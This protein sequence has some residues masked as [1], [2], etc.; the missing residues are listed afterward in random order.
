[1]TVKEY[2]LSRVNSGKMPAKLWMCF[3]DAFGALWSEL[4]QMHVT[5]HLERKYSRFLVTRRKRI[6]TIAWLEDTIQPTSK[7][8]S[9]RMNAFEWPGIW[10]GC[11]MG[12]HKLFNVHVP[13]RIRWEFVIENECKGRER[14]LTESKGTEYGFWVKRMRKDYQIN[15]SPFVSSEWCIRHN[16]TPFEQLCSNFLVNVSFE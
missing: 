4:H 15:C 1:M 5:K 14:K 11:S 10:H 9:L 7:F 12:E 2:M 6:S 13:K 8:T 3:V 16:M